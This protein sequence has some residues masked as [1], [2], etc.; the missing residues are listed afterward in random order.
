MDTTNIVSVTRYAY[1]ATTGN[2]GNIGLGIAND[3]MTAVVAPLVSGTS[4]FLRAY[5]SETN[6]DWYLTAV[7]PNTGATINNR[8]LAIRYWVVKFKRL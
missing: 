7:N 6:G 2:T 3:G 8:E 5:V 1:K 4:V